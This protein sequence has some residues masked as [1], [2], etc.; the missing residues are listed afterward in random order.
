MSVLEKLKGMF[1]IEINKP[2]INICFKINSDNVTKTKKEVIYLE[3]ENKLDI[4]LDNIGHDK[5]KK[6]KPLIR[7]YIELEDKK[8][9]EEKTAIRL[10]EI[11][12]Y[13]Q[14]PGDDSKTR[15][16]FKNIIPSVDY[17]ALEAALY[18]RSEFNKGED[19]S[20]LKQDIR[21]T[22]G[23]RGSNIANLCTAGYFEGFL[24]PLFNNESIERFKELYELIVGKAVIAVFVHSGMKERDITRQIKNKINVS[25]RYGIPI[26]YIHGIG[27][28]NVAKIKKFIEE[29][30]ELSN[31]FNK[32]IYESDDGGII[33]V[34]LL[35][36]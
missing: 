14:N 34:E 28:D 7:E 31:F 9:L 11:C 22:F 2:L 18:I 17:E 24:K 13:N 27:P 15:K 26:L 35:L 23:E 3:A 33:I 25:M 6:L 1:N 5:K 29:K 4:L 21:E 30:E 19:V 32:T 20:E 12:L 16:F 10:N 8:L 36:K